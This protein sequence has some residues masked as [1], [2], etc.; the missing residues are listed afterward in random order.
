LVR[1]RHAPATFLVVVACAAVFV[2]AER[3]GSTEKAATLLQ[4]GATERAHVW[5][6]E[7]WRLAT[8]MFLH[9]GIIHLVWNLYASWGWCVPIERA[10]GSRRFLVGYLLC[11][12]GGSIASVLGHD[13]VSAGAS[14]AAFGIIGITLVLYRRRLVTWSA[15]FEAREVRQILMTAALWTVVGLTAISM[16]NFAHGGGLLTGVAAG[17]L[18]TAKQ[19][20]RGHVGSWFGFL[21]VLGG[22]VVLAAHPWRL[23]SSGAAMAASYASAYDRG[24]GV[25][26]NPPRAIKFAQRGCDGGSAVACTILGISYQRGDIVLRDT[27]LAMELLQRACNADEPFG[28]SAGASIAAS[29]DGTPRDDALAVTLWRRAC[30]LGHVQGCA[31]FGMM[32]AQGRSV[33]QDRERGLALLRTACAANDAWACKTAN[34]LER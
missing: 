29:G 5:I 14:G 11:G 26:R 3:Q 10:L 17:W 21:V 24:E 33:A 13:A 2:A 18:L 32:V 25:V 22:A 15:F 34:A 30:D 19:S 27:A 28:C 31:G 23:S 20:R 9:I 16:D 7:Y 1:L 4:F 6:G 8:S 12:I